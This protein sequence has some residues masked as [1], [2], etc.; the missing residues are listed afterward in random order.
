MS[1]KSKV[2][3]KV[4]G[5]DFI[6]SSEDSEEYIRS[7]AQTVEKSINRLVNYNG[8]M[9]LAM[10]A[11]FSALEFC[12]EATKATEAADNLRTQ[13]KSYLED[14]SRSKSEASELR[15]REQQL[16]RENQELREKL[17][18]QNGRP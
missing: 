14:A 9:S 15:R 16:T 4:C 12:D 1:E 18:H 10:A 7:V 5:Y 13:I 3:L 17:R 2:G 6:I 11:I 8:S